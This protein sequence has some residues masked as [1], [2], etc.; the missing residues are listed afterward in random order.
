MEIPGTT[1]H[2]DAFCFVL[3]LRRTKEEIY[4]A[5]NHFIPG[6]EKIDGNYCFNSGIGKSFKGEDEILSYLEG[7][8]T[9]KGTIYW[10]KSSDNPDKIM[11]GAR[12]TSDRQLIIS[13]TLNADNIKEIVYF[14]ALKALLNSKVGVV[15]YNMLP[16]FSDGEDFR[17]KY[18]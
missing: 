14:E 15:F 13:L 12:F 17:K 9:V 1:I 5:L 4:A 18:G 2:G 3:A 7:N 6:Y 8:S 11:I 16:P 10:R